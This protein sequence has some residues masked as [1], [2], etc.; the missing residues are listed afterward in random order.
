[1]EELVRRKSNIDS[2]NQKIIDGCIASNNL[3]VMYAIFPNEEAGDIEN[4]I[5]CLTV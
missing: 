5:D 4:L 3:E 1:M 2:A